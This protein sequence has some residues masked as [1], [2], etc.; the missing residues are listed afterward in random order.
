MLYQVNITY[1]DNGATTGIDEIDAPGDYTAEDYIKDCESNADE[2]WIEL[3]H[4]GVI[5]L[6]R[7]ED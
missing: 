3:V 5:K 7:V 4:S 2:D 1:Y 6:W